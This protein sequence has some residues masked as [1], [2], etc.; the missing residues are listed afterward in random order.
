MGS[1]SPPP[2]YDA[3][4]AAK[5][6][7]EYNLK[8]AVQQYG[9]NATNQ[10]TPYG[11]LSY[12]QIGTWEDGTPRF[13]S[14]QSLSPEEQNLYDIGTANQQKLGTIGGQQ[15]DRVGELLSR[16]ISLDNSATEGRL[17]ELARSRLDPILQTQQNQLENKLANQGITSGSEAWKTEMDQFGRNRNDAYNNLLLSGRGQ[18]VNELL[19]ERNQPL[20][21]ITALMSGSQVQQPSF[22]NTP[23][24][25]VANT[26]YLGASQQANQNALAGWNSKNQYNQALMGGLFGIAGAGAGGWARGGF[27]NPFASKSA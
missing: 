14:T 7:G 24:V 2:T 6:Q 12:K 16:P 27:N 3:T 25:G 18:A 4:N 13:E 20:N 5:T 1:P 15:I 21:E 8:S 11:S 22:T 19:T 23:Q 26:D 17:N 9:L 10:K